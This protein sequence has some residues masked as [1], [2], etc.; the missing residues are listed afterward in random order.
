MG[1]ASH[2]DTFKA[3]WNA[4][5]GTLSNAPKIKVSKYANPGSDV[6]DT[7]RVEFPP[8]SL[9]HRAQKQVGAVP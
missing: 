8:D 6:D 7:V 4:D 3:V 1:Y 5:K 9:G 2:N